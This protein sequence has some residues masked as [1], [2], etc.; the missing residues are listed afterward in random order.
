MAFFPLVFVVVGIHT[1]IYIYSTSLLYGR[2]TNFFIFADKR[3]PSDF[4]V[5]AI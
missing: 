1:H 5:E 4:V 2:F 3:S